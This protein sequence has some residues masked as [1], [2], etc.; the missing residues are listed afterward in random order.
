MRPLHSHRAMVIF[1]AVSPPSV[2]SV[3]ATSNLYYGSAFLIVWLV[4]MIFAVVEGVGKF[5]QAMM[6]DKYQTET[7]KWLGSRVIPLVAC[8]MIFVVIAVPAKYP[9]WLCVSVLG[10]LGVI[11]LCLSNGYVRQVCEIDSAMANSLD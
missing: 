9:E 10:A 5:T 6:S 4:A 8:Q 11:T 7:Q 3:V 1:C 2:F